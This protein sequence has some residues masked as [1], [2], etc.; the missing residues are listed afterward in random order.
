M[1][2]DEDAR[3]RAWIACRIMCGQLQPRSSSADHV[4]RDRADAIDLFHG[5]VY[6]RV[7]A[8]H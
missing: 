5:D 8:L 3:A 1:D 7:G 2:N 6:F 4:A